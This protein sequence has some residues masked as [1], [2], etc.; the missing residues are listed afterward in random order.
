MPCAALYFALLN[1]RAALGVSPLP[2]PGIVPGPGKSVLVR[3]VP[4]LD[5]RIFRLRGS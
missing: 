2:C 3:N 5:L 1:T 4:H